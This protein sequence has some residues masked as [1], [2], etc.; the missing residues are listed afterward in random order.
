MYSGMITLEQKNMIYLQCFSILLFQSNYE[1]GHLQ[2]HFYDEHRKPVLDVLNKLDSSI[3]IARL[4]NGQ[5]VSAEEYYKRMSSA[6]IL[7]APFGYGE[8]APRDLQAAQFG[9]VLVKP[10]MSYI[11]TYLWHESTQINLPDIDRNFWKTFFCPNN[12]DKIHRRLLAK[13]LIRYHKDESLVYIRCLARV[14]YG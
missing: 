5:R 4:Q 3:K 9:A 8:M 1:H 10:D 12:A 6:R 13:H 7:L 2:S 11:D 14:S